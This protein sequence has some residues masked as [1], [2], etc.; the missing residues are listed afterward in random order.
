MKRI[1]LSVVLG[2][3]WVAALSLTSGC[4]ASEGPYFERSRQ[5]QPHAFRNRIHNPADYRYTRAD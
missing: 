2:S 3:L 1:F 4:T 5:N